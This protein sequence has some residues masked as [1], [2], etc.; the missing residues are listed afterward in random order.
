MVDWCV[1]GPWHCAILVVV[2]VCIS[3]VASLTK[4]LQIMLVVSCCMC[5]MRQEIAKLEV[6]VHC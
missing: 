5:E 2:A 3:A 1:W 6:K 4:L